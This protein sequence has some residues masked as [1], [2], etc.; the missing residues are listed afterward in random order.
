MAAE[1]GQHDI[2][3]HCTGLVWDLIKGGLQGVDLLAGGCGG[4][5]RPMAQGG[6]GAWRVLLDEHCQV[7]SP[8]KEYNRHSQ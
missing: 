1:G 4:V 7:R 2:R 5:G 3:C 8:L 6:L